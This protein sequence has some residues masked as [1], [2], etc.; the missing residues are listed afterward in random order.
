MC[1][2]ITLNQGK[3]HSMRIKKQNN[4]IKV[5]VYHDLVNIKLLN[6]NRK[7]TRRYRE[8]RGFRLALR[9]ETSGRET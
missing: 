4:V 9:G 8:R 7:G 3:V 2:K 1:L 6:I 5:S